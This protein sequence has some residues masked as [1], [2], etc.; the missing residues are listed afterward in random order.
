MVVLS[1]IGRRAVYKELLA[2]PQL[3]L[4]NALQL[5]TSMRVPSSRRS[6]LKRPS[7]K[8]LNVFRAP[9]LDIRSWFWRLRTPVSGNQVYLQ[10]RWH[11]IWKYHQ[12]Q[13]A[14]WNTGKAQSIIIPPGS[15]SVRRSI[16]HSKHLKK[17]FTFSLI[18]PNFKNEWFS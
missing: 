12:N 4:I 5:G 8:F 15:V 13:C 11:P 3:T 6:A 18:M 9:S 7:K 10:G 2:T 1:T 17:L 16:S 14:R